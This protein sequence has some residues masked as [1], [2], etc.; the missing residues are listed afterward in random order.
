MPK[1]ASC[2]AAIAWAATAHGKRMPLDA[3][4]AADGTIGRYE[5][6]ETGADMCMVVPE[7]ERSGW[8]GR[9]YRSH[10]S[11]CPS[12]GMHRRRK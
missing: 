8:G 12:A 7:S 10:F 5:C 1:C 3:A 2:G 9:L 6:A 4:P 11:T